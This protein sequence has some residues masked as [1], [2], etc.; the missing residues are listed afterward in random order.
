MRCYVIAV[1]VLYYNLS[2]VLFLPPVGSGCNV[3]NFFLWPGVGMVLIICLIDHF[4]IK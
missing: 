2:I 1:H 3:L 4:A